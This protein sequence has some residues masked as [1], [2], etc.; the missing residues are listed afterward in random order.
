MMGFMAR[1]DNEPEKTHHFTTVHGRDQSV[2]VAVSFTDARGKRSFILGRG[3]PRFHDKTGQCITDGEGKELKVGK[4]KFVGGMMEDLPHGPNKWQGFTS[5]AA[6][7]SAMVHNENIVAMDKNGNSKAPN[8]FSKNF[9]HKLAHN[10]FKE[11]EEEIGFNPQILNRNRN[12]LH[13]KCQPSLH[14]MGVNHGAKS[15]RGKPMDVHFLHLDLGRLSANEIETLKRTTRP[16]DDMIQSLIVDENHL[17]FD[18]NGV[19]FARLHEGISCTKQDFNGFPEMQEWTARRAAGIGRLQAA[20][21]AAI[22][23]LPEH[24]SKQREARRGASVLRHIHGAARGLEGVDTGSLHTSDPIPIMSS[25]A[26]IIQAILG[27]PLPQ[28]SWSLDVLK[29]SAKKGASR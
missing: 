21:V 23:Q 16:A 17:Q 22:G 27:A 15:M 1:T 20:R 13:T 7:V 10:A 29:P 11:L 28:Q 14:Y 25:N 19:M 5:V 3:D 4:L 2:V 8:E 6:S 9:A 24:K 18:A 12:H 26:A